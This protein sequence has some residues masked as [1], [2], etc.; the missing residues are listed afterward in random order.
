[1]LLRVL[2]TGPVLQETKAKGKIAAHTAVSSTLE[3]PGTR[4]TR[5]GSKQGPWIP[6]SEHEGSPRK[7][8][9]RPVTCKGSWGLHPLP[10]QI[11]NLGSD[12]GSYPP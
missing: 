9:P 3:I 11:M 7:R 4:E 5:E 2:Y 12:G 6:G 1:M 10:A 8:R